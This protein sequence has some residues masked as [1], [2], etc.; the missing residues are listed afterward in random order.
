MKYPPHWKFIVSANIAGCL[1]LGAGI[2]LIAAAIHVTPKGY[3]P[4]VVMVLAWADYVRRPKSEGEIRWNWLALCLLALAAIGVAY[5]ISPNE[6]TVV[7][8]YWL[9]AI[10]MTVG[11]PLFIAL[12][13]IVVHQRV[14]AAVLR[15][16]KAVTPPSHP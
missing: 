13:V 7:L 6:I 2:M 14:C 16:R 15:E 5:L 8:L 1:L 10:M 9:M 4:G 11:A 12:A 3:I